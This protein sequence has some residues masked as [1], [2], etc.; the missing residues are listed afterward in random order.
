MRSFVPRRPKTE[1]LIQL[2]TKFHIRMAAVNTKCMRVAADKVT[3][4]F[5]IH[6]FIHFV[7]I[8]FMRSA[9]ARVLRRR[10]GTTAADGPDLWSRTES[11]QAMREIIHFVF[12][13]IFV[14]RT[15]E[16]VSWNKTKVSSGQNEQMRYFHPCV[17]QIGWACRS[18]AVFGL[19]T[20]LS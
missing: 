15:L 8:K 17:D 19:N 12:V 9:S 10:A 5:L 6:A 13:V 7:A 16:H 20:L 4:L 11:T 2:R 14:C 3:T 18:C 1:T